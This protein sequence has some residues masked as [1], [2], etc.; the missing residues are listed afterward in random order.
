MKR[1]SLYFVAPKQVLLQ[2][3]DCPDPG[4]GEVLVH[5]L[6]SAISAGTEMLMYRGLFPP[7]L[8]VDDSISSLAGKLA[9]P[10][11]YGYATVGKVAALGGHVDP[12]WMGKSVFAFHSHE[13]AFVARID[14]LHPVPAA[15][16]QEDALFLPNMETAVNF[17]LD[18]QPL[19]GEHALVLGQGIVGLLTTALLARTP[20]AS[21]I[22]LD[23]FP[24]R[25][26]A[27]LRAGATAALDPE[28]AHITEMLQSYWEDPRLYPGADLTFEL[29]GNPAALDR[30]IEL[31]GFGG[32]IVIGSWYGQKPATLHLGGRF[33]RSRL[34]LIS[35][36]V[37]TLTP[38]LSGRW[39]KQRRLTFAW[40]MLEVVRPAQFITHRF[41]FEQAPDAYH[42]IDSDPADV[43][44]VIFKYSHAN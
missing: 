38:E 7:D 29:T 27:A 4:P 34:R 3:E 1:H 44:Q 5:V 41:R 21:L 31:T 12:L 6:A 22:A 17:L 39:N 32:R 23:R 8:S 28:E 33:H 10:L 18:G 26:E 15:I 42:Q 2:E 14:D 43:I 19:I 13:T 30:A 36:Q 40:K 16:S 25:R 11:K 37:S 24:K 35:S 20:L 9:Y